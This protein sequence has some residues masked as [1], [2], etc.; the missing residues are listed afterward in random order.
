[1]H[2]K[3]IFFILLLSFFTATLAINCGRVPS[4]ENGY[5]SQVGG[6]DVGER[7]P[8]ICYSGYKIEGSDYYATCGENGEWTYD[9]KC[10]VD[11]DA[12]TA[13]RRSGNSE[14]TTASPDDGLLIPVWAIVVITI[15]AVGLTAL[16]I[17][18][19]YPYCQI[20]CCY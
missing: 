7:R 2:N 20:A 9:A 3:T 14:T 13:R 15:L 4:I 10:V 8:I 5:T 12:T 17:G 19:L 1:M 18:L 11:N 6:T 16:M